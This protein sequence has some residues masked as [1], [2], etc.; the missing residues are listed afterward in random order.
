MCIQHVSLETLFKE[1][2]EQLTTASI[3]CLLALDDIPSA[4]LQLNN[5]PQNQRTPEINALF[6]VARGLTAGPTQTELI[7][8]AIHAFTWNDVVASIMTQLIESTRQKTINTIESSYNSLPLALAANKIGLSTEETTQ[9]FVKAGWELNTEKQTLYRT[10]A[11]TPSRSVKPTLAKD[12]F[13]LL[14]DHVL[15]MERF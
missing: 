11:A 1:E 2:R 15:H 14:T 5:I 6:E 4:T 9:L 12:P 7:F 10:A 8:Q 13:A 3:A